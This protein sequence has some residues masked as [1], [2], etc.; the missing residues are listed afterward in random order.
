MAMDVL[1]F[2]NPKVASH[3]D[4][5][6]MEKGRLEQMKAE[7]EKMLRECKQIFSQSEKFST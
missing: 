7:I 1:M 6:S 2:C 5:A 3:C 4:N